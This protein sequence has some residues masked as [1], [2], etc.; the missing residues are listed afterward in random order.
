MTGVDL[1]EQS[2]LL[3]LLEASDSVIADEG[4][5]IQ[6]LLTSVGVRLNIPALR[7]GERAF[8]PAN[9]P[10]TKQI[11]AVRTRVE[12]TINHIKKFSYLWH[13]ARQHKGYFTANYPCLFISNQSPDILGWEDQSYTESNEQVC[14][15]SI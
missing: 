3:S 12:S 6:H 8:S 14:V 13:N 11:A 7:H 15:S 10:K 9:V 4:L 2:C 5:D 1:V